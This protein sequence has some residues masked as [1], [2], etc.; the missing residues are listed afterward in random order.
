MVLKDLVKFGELL[1][2]RAR[3]RL[4]KHRERF[5]HDMQISA[6]CV[7]RMNNQALPLEREKKRDVNLTE[8]MRMRQELEDIFDEFRL[9]KRL[10]NEENLEIMKNG[11][12]T[13]VDQTHKDC[14]YF[15]T[16][17]TQRL[18][19]NERLR[20]ALDALAE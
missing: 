4:L 6:N 10:A 15:E 2:N 19:A 16:D 3:Q 20:E 13:L 12:R 14:M 5:D 7:K 17:R 9:E 1:I 8:K 18:S 11:L